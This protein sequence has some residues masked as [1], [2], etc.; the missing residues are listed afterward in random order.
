MQNIFALKF[1][2]DTLL[3]ASVLHWHLIVGIKLN[4]VKGIIM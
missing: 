3:V 4:P 1:E 2:V